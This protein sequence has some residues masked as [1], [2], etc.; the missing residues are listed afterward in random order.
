MGIDAQCYAY[1]DYVQLVH[2]LQPYRIAKDNMAVIGYSLGAGTA[3]AYQLNYKLDLLICLD[4]S[5]LGYNY[6]VVKGNTKR[7]IL[8]TESNPFSGPLGHAVPKGFDVVKV[9]QSVHLWIDL[10]PV[11]V[12]DVL[13]EL[14]ALKER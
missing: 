11:I 2:D 7:S 9:S 14:R 4:P 1:T 6:N 10:D 12:G 8:W 3:E 5:Q 13:G